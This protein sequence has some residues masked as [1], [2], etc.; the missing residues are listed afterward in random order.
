MG[1]HDPK[2]GIWKLETP[3][4]D[5]RG[6]LGR[7]VAPRDDWRKTLLAEMGVQGRLE[8]TLIPDGWEFV[9][10]CLFKELLDLGWN[11][12]LVSAVDMH[13]GLLVELGADRS[14]AMEFA[15]RRAQRWSFSTCSRC[16]TSGATLR[17]RGRRMET[18]C[19]T[20]HDTLMERDER[21]AHG[22]Y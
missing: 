22:L 11:R 18:T 5:P 15:C 8:P 14:P 20:C 16:G 2:E 19:A 7:E 9:L 1:E 12:Q 6:V 17:P 10:R 13:G 21:S 3:R 4:F